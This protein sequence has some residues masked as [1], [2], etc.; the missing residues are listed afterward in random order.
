MDNLVMLAATT[1]S[2]LPYGNYNIA[3]T[4]A[5]KLICILLLMNC[6]KVAAK[7]CR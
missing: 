7:D 6:R 3:A 1:T 4:I 2:L 5:A